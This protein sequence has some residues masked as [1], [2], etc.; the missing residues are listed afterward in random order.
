LID[1]SKEGSV[2]FRFII[3]PD[4]KREDTNRD[5]HLRDIA[6]HTMQTLAER[7]GKQVSWVGAIHADH[8]PHRHVHVVAVV[9]G[10]LQRN[11]LQALTRAAT[12]ASLDQR[13]EHDLTHEAL[14]Q[15]KEREAEEEAQWE[16]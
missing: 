9:E 5:L 3:S 1:E 6:D 8:A 2:F 14:R 11:D 7:V 4:P 10:R 16:R 15:E 13:S 12:E